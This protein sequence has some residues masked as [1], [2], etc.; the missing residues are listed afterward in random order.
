MVE[1]LNVFEP[2]PWR[3]REQEDDF[4]VI[5]NDS[6][7]EIIIPEPVYILNMGQQNAFDWLIKFCLNEQDFCKV[8]LEG[9]AGVGKSF[10]LNRMVEGALKRDRGLGF[11]MTAPTH[12]AVRVLKRDSELKDKLD[13]GTIHSFLGLKEKV[14]DVT[15]K[16]TYEPEYLAGKP[17]RIEGVNV[18]IVDESSMLSDE[19]FEHIETEMRSNRYLKVIYTGDPLQIPP[20]GKK[21]KTGVATAIPFILERRQSHSIAHLVLSEPQR[22]AK[23]SPIIMYATAIRE[24]HNRQVVDFDFKEE[25]THALE[26]VPKNIQVLTELLTKYFKSPEFEEDADYVKVIAWRNNVVNY[27]NNLIRT[28]IY[29]SETLPK[30]VRGEA[31]VM[32]KPFVLRDKILIPNNEEVIVDSVQVLNTTIKYVEL[33]KATFTTS[34]EAVELD[35]N[36]RVT[37]AW[38]AKVYLLTVIAPDEKRYQLTVLHED[39]EK[40]YE[41]IRGTLESAAKKS[42]DQFD[43]KEM[44]KQFYSVERAFAWVKYNYAVTAHKA[45]GSSYN[46][47]FSMEFDMNGNKDIPERNSLKYVAAT[48]SRTKLFIIK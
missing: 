8:T 19:L 32:D 33:N 36:G 26:V 40:D 6:E 13:F 10:L 27:F 29:G 31:L 24:Q 34:K 43:R 22:Q 12:K 14:D 17:R 3:S 16:V 23:E 35:S 42:R 45:Q 21:Q 47:T 46:Y 5:G 48:R 39:S 44:W 7:K 1:Q 9:W 37:K 18:L 41:N 30:F 38:E 28:I 4:P 25:Y 15:G 11:G 20:V 2:D